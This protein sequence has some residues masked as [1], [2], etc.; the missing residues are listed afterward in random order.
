MRDALHAP[1]L[2]SKLL[3]IHKLTMDL[4]CLVTFSPTL[5]KFK[6]QGTGKMVRVAREENGLY[7]FEEACGTCSTMSQLPLSLLS[8]S[9]PSHNKDIWLCHYRLGHPSFSTLKIMFPSLFQGLDIGVFHCDDWEFSKHKHVSIPISN[10]RMSV[11][12]SLV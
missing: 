8:K 4:Q 6:D 9:L 5:C 3:S 7:L 2:S 12:F 11:P 10:K 1:K